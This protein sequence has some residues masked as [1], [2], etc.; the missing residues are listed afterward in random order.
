M[1][2]I[3]IGMRMG[4]DLGDIEFGSANAAVS[5]CNEMQCMHLLRSMSFKTDIHCFY[6]TPALLWEN[7][8]LREE[9]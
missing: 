1:D 8:I 4:F 7:S 9:Q 2:P 3:L 5:K 6:N